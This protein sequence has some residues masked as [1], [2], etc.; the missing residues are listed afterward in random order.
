MPKVTMLKTVNGSVDGIN[1][2]NFVEGQTYD[3]P[4]KLANDFASLDAIELCAEQPQEKAEHAAPK[5]KANKQAPKN[6]SVSGDK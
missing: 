6:K 1:A 2:M 4:D 5:N 3:I